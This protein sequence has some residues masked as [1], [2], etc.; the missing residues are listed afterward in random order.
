M[1]CGFELKLKDSFC[2]KIK[3]DHFKFGKCLYSSQKV[4]V[5]NTLDE[6]FTKD[7]YLNA[8]KMQENWFPSLDAD[9]FISHSH[10]DE[11]LAISLA[12]WLNEKLNIK[13]VFID[14]CVWGYANDLLKS[15]DNEYCKNKFSETY[16]YEKR[17]ISTS[18]VHMMLSTALSKMLDNSECCFFL[19][20]PASVSRF[21][22]RHNRVTVD[23]FRNCNDKA[24]KAKVF[25]RP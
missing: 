14:S 2:N 25:K 4:L 5:K 9:I 1:Y 10:R 6:F 15:I 13:S 11:E 22:G 16:D 24:D 17:N 23:I 12:G 19:H 8:E 7:G 20:T 21:A 18:H 3:Q